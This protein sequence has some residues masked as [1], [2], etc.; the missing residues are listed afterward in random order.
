MQSA[1][2]RRIQHTSTSQNISI[3]NSSVLLGCSGQTTAT[4]GTVRRT[5]SEEEL[6][7]IYRTLSIREKIEFMEKVYQFEDKMKKEPGE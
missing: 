3:S 4:N 2:P 1:K 5:E 6:L 7:R